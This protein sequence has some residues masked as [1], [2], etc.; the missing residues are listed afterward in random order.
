MRRRDVITLLGGAAA[1]WPL[2]AR[3]QQSDRVRR[4]GVLI[5]VAADDAE[6]KARLAAFRQ[7]LRQLGWVD[8]RNVQIDTRWSGGDPERIRTHAAELVTL[9]PDVILAAGGVVVGPLLQ[10]TRTVPIVFTQTPDPVGAGFVAS[11]ARPGGNATGFALFEFG[12][13][14]KWLELLKEIAPRVTRAAALRDPAIPAGL[15]QL[16]AIQGVAPSF[17]V[18]L[19]FVDVRDAPEIERA[20]AAFARHANTGMIVLSSAMA[21]VHRDLIIAL[22]A[23]HKLPAVYSARYFVTSG[24]LISYGPDTI[25]PHRSA[26]A[27][28]D[29]IL[30]GEKPADLPVQEPTRYELAINLMTAKALGLDVPATLLARADEV[31]E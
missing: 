17:G 16:G 23:R 25:E 18:E 11:L 27:Y 14:V 13:S 8:G 24:G 30:K 3:A 15:G 6:A 22:A 4:I 19:S 7:G 29:R 26:A 5:P 1:A 20:V 2:A 21:I 12:I 31:I 9:T 10:A 28:V